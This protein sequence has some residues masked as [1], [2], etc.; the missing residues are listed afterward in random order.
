VEQARWWFARLSRPILELCR[1]HLPAHRGLGKLLRVIPLTFQTIVQL[2]EAEDDQL[3]TN[4]RS[5]PILISSIRQ[6]AASPPPSRS[7]QRESGSDEEFEDDGNDQDGEGEISALARRIL[8][9]SEEAAARAGGDEQQF[10][11]GQGGQREAQ[12][13]SHGSDHAALRASV[14]R[15][16]SGQ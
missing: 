16:L 3:T 4:I 2:L 6:L 11:A 14:H 10:T 8:D 5:S 13:G 9:L 1:Y 12:V 15:A 7:G